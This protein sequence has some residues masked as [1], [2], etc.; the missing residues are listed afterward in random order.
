MFVKVSFVAAASVAAFAVSRIKIQ[1][2]R[3]RNPPIKPAEIDDSSFQQEEIEE[4]GEEKS[5]DSEF[6]V[7]EEEEIKG[8]TTRRK[9]EQNLNLP[10]RRESGN[11]QDVTGE[12]GILQN[13]V[14]EMERKRRTLEGKLLEM[15]GIKEQRSYIAQLQ[16][17]LKVKT[18]EVDFLSIT[19]N[20]LRAE[21]KKLQEEAKEG[22]LVEKQLEIAKKRIK[23]LHEKMTTDRNWARKKLLTLARE[24]SGFEKTGISSTDHE[25]VEKKSGSVEFKAMEMK[26]RNKELEMETGGLKI[27]LV[28]AEDKANA[29][30]DMTEDKLEEEM[31]KFRH[32]NESLS[33]QI[34]KLR[35]NRFG[36]IEE[37]MYQRSLNACLRFESQNYLT[38]PILRKNSSQE[39]HGNKTP[40][41]I[42]HHNSYSK[43]SSS[44]SIDRT[45]IDSSS[46]SERSISKKYGLI[47]NIRRWGRRK[48]NPRLVVSS[49]ER[50]SRENS[51]FKAGGLIRRLSMSDVP[52]QRK[53]NDSTGLVGI[54]PSR[55]IKRV[56]FSTQSQEVQSVF[57][58]E[59]NPIDTVAWLRSTGDLDDKKNT[60][61]QSSRAGS[62]MGGD[63]KHEVSLKK[64]SH[65]RDLSGTDMGNGKVESGDKEELHHSNML[66]NVLHSDSR[67]WTPLRS[68]SFS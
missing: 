11:P 23:E 39:S 42:P 36:I 68:S 21:T 47:H 63:E 25:N 46:S 49:S 7:E 34:E 67:V 57:D 5:A 44:S 52:L 24:V 58:L 43:S 40:T 19:V 29:L 54:T 45:T 59:R 22:V 1:S 37:L 56:Q 33:K 38:P 41:P 6:S 12:I 48:D 8:S 2:S 53:E 26:R 64:A 15:Y 51:P 32:A 50:S 55:K 31:N 20:S 28:A 13:A 18:E 14:K 65:C 9:M 10:K 66:P 30:S 3:K 60:A 16:K 62:L 27:M 4:D 61:M 17:H 35:K